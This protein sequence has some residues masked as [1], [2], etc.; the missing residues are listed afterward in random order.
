MRCAAFA[1]VADTITALLAGSISCFNGTCCGLVLLS[2]F[3]VLVVASFSGVEDRLEVT[4]RAISHTLVVTVGFDEGSTLL[5]AASGAHSS[6]WLPPWSPPVLRLR[7]AV[8][9][10]R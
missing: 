2:S 7:D 3:P 8:H 6:A 4:F 1:V 5:L 9:A 10:V